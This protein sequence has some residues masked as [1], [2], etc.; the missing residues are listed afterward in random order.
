MIQLISSIS[1]KIQDDREVVS[2]HVLDRGTKTMQL[3]CPRIIFFYCSKCTLQNTI[4]E[5]RSYKLYKTM[6]C[7]TGIWPL[8]FSF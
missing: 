4:F 7:N 3:G 1:G 5:L 6:V 2:M 8:T